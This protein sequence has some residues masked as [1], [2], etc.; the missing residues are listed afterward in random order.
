MN[1]K[2]SYYC[3]TPMEDI[4]SGKGLRPI[5]NPNYIPPASAKKSVQEEY[6]PDKYR[7]EIALRYDNTWRIRVDGARQFALE[8][9][10]RVIREIERLGLE[11][12]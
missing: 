1:N 4:I 8:P 6:R 10:A 7:V 11:E 5:P 3:S 9:W 2:Y 12:L